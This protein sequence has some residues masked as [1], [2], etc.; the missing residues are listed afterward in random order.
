MAPWYSYPNLKQPTATNDNYQ[1]L[2]LDTKV[3][4]QVFADDDTNDHLIAL[5][6]IWEKLPVGL[7][8]KSWQLIHSDGC[9]GQWLN[10]GHSVPATFN[11]MPVGSGYNAHDVW[12][13]ARRILALADYSFHGGGASARAIAFPR[14]EAERSMGSWV[15][16]GGRPIVPLEASETT[17]IFSGCSGG[18]GV[19]TR[20]YVFDYSPDAHCRFADQ[21][22][23]L[24]R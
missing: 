23:P 15:D 12:A 14:S 13:V 2:P 4:I 7:V 5:H 16:C 8:D 19:G 9:N 24:C 11:G 6:D 22:A 3:I 20:G 21:G 10:A 18:G 1:S 17:P